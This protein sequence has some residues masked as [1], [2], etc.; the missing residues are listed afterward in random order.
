MLPRADWR[1]V[2]GPNGLVPCR[3]LSLRLADNDHGDFQIDFFVF[4]FAFADEAEHQ[5]FEVV[6][7]QRWLLLN[8]GRIQQREDGWMS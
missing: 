1:N 3:F 2:P 7:F 5:M 6:F 8:L 4:H